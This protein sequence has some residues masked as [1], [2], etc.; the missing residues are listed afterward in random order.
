ML[1]G[2]GTDLDEPELVQ[3]VYLNDYADVDLAVFEPLTSLR[4]LS[5][6][7]ATTV[8]PSI[9][10]LKALESLEIAA[11]SVDLAALAGH[12]T[13]WY[14]QL[15]AVVEPLDIAP[16]RTLP[17]LVRLDLAESA[18]QNIDVVCDMPNLR[19]LRL[20]AEQLRRL[21]DS[22]KPLPKL[23]A[24]YIA[25]RTCLKDTVELANSRFGQNVTLTEFTGSLT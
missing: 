2:P 14:V 24:L 1:D 23:A 10:G 4:A 21:L 8:T 17:R 16:L 22:G 25:G 12:P 19:V 15:A 18:V 3:R 11:D 7:S 13:L 5:V 6:N 9:G 20:D